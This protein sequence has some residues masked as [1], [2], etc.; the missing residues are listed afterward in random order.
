[1]SPT[2]PRCLRTARY[3]RT[4]CDLRRTDGVSGWRR[5]KRTY[6]RKRNGERSSVSSRT[7]AKYLKATRPRRRRRNGSGKAVGE[8]GWEEKASWMSKGGKVEQ[9]HA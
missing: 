5:S 3:G 9:F 6:K 8:D 2:A 7:T 1:H 4:V